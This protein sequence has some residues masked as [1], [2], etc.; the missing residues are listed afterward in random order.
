MENAKIV[1]LIKFIKFRIAFNY[2]HT[3]HIHFLLNKYK[4]RNIE[5]IFQSSPEINAA[6]EPFQI[7][8]FIKELNEKTSGQALLSKLN[9]DLYL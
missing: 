4:C 8:K 6:I 5:S 1:E 9:S 7:E 2:E 3:S